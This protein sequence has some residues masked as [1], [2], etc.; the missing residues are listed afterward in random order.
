MEPI[1]RLA[2]QR[3]GSPTCLAAER[4]TRAESAGLTADFYGR[5]N[6][7]IW[8]ST[9]VSSGSSDLPTK[10]AVGKWGWSY[11]NCETVIFGTV[12]VLIIW[13]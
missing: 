3:E 10:T 13:N 7:R 2:I 4:P 1:H 11:I 9:G 12:S 8:D 5:V 6:D